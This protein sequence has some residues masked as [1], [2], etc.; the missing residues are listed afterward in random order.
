VQGRI[1]IPDLHE[2]THEQKDAVIVELMTS[3][4]ALMARVNALEAK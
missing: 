1:K 3:L 2:L 4:N